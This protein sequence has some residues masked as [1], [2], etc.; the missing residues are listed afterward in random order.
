MLNLIRV[1][2]ASQ[3]D[4]VLDGVVY[5]DA[6]KLAEKLRE[7]FAANPDAWLLISPV[8]EE[9][10]R[11]TGKAIYASQSAGVLPERLRYKTREGEIISFEEL[12][13]RAKW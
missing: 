1:D 13:S 12:K 3:E 4:V 6:G 5:K 8:E 2:I 10:Y 9:F 7:N 11:G